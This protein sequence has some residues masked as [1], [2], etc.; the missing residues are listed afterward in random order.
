M[1]I[2]VLEAKGLAW[3]TFTTLRLLRLVDNQSSSSGYLM[4]DPCPTSLFFLKFILI[5]KE[6]I[7]AEGS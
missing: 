5:L 6:F 2:P 3:R 4:V 7:P 1:D